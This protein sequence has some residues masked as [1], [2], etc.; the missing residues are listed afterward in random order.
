[1]NIKKERSS[2]RIHLT[3]FFHIRLKFFS[4]T[5]F[6]SS[7]WQFSLLLLTSVVIIVIPPYT[8]YSFN[9]SK[10]EMAGKLENSVFFLCF[11]SF[12][13]SPKH[14]TFHLFSLHTISPIIWVF[15]FNLQC[16]FSSL[17]IFSQLFF[18]ASFWSLCFLVHFLD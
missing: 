18:S 2:I 6:S 8:S 5:N 13:D 14:F 4:S 1:L 12:W 16:P 3:H 7:F 11:L 10:Y 17:S 15:I 9:I